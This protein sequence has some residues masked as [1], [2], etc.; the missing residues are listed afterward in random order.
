M[1]FYWIVLDGLILLG[2]LAY[3]YRKRALSRVTYSRG[4]DRTTAFE[5][6][7]VEMVET[8]ENRKLLPVPWLR[9]ESL[10][11]VAL[12]FHRQ[13]N[14]DIHAGE[15]FQNHL[16]LFSLRPYRR[17]V[18]RHEIRCAKRG[19]YALESATMT[20]GEP[21]GLVQASRRFA[22]ENLRL[23]VYPRLV[24]LREIPLPNHGWLGDLSVRRWIVEDPF[25]TA[26]I[27][28][29]GPGDP[30]SRVHWKATA[31]TGKLQVQ[32][33]GHTADHRLVLCLNVEINETMWKTVTDPERI[34]V[35]IRYA[36]SIADD[37]I[38]RGMETGLLCNGWML[39]EPKAPIRVEPAGGAVQL[40]ALLTG[41]AKLQ[42][43]S[44][45]NMA[46]LLEQ[47]AERCP[48]RT[49]YLIL[50]CHREE[51]LA[52]AAERL[53]RMGNGVEWVIIPETGEKAGG[54]DHEREP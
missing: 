5:G 36:A 42:L 1:P 46:Y 33:K 38:G 9:L 35:G 44:A 14:L 15:M 3:V 16:S 34:E 41:L 25:L 8:I 21:L 18:R 11:P 52:S 4:F 45:S 7:L 22:M 2:I 12:R 48:G 10:M 17:I 32:V 51:K 30:L 40:G 29:Y 54:D 49:D 37:A 24:P 43:E 53:R 19:F 13:S 28:E 20:A 6:E 31:R 23:L 39:G 50:T 26:G 27:R 47:E